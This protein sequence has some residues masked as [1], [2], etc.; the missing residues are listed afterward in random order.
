MRILAPCV[1]VRVQ[2]GGLLKVGRHHMSSSLIRFRHGVQSQP[3]CRPTSSAG[4]TPCT[5]ARYTLRRQP[6]LG[7]PCSTKSLQDHGKA[8]VCCAGS[9]A[10]DR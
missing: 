6:L 4:M 5:S 10:Q 7:P 3:L 2:H 8:F 1:Q 9:R